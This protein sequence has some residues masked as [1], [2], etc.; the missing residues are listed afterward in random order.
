MLD[1]ICW[2]GQAASCASLVVTKNGTGYLFLLHQQLLFCHLEKLQLPLLRRHFQVD[3][4]RMR[5][6]NQTISVRSNKYRNYDWPPS[7]WS[8]IT[9]M[10]S[11]HAVNKFAEN[12]CFCFCINVQVFQNWQSLL[13]IKQRRAETCFKESSWNLQIWNNTNAK[14]IWWDNEVGHFW[15][16][17]VR[18]MHVWRNSVWTRKGLPLQRKGC[19]ICNRAS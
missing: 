4:F 8:P 15:K 12:V 19:R 2:R 17:L 11:D 6:S 13:I 10:V 7:L 14:K 18:K 9:N 3:S 1:T 16:T 5:M